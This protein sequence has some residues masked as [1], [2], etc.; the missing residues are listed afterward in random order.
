MLMEILLVKFN[1][2]VSMEFK[3]PLIVIQYMILFKT[4]IIYSKVMFRLL[5]QMVSIHISL[6]LNNYTILYRYVNLNNNA[7]WDNLIK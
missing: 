4:T 7:Y 3:Y 2:T 1:F 5:L 6:L